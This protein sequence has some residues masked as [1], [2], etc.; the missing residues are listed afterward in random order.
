MKVDSPCINICQID[1]TKSFC[2]GCSR[3]IKEISEWSTYN[4]KQKKKILNLLL[5]RK[6]GGFYLI[7]YFYSLYLVKFTQKVY[8]WESGLLQ[9]NGNQNLQLS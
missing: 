3:T 9:I 2:I 8:G 5:E 4:D 1:E 7:F 6:K